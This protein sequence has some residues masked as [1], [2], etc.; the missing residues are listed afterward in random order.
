MR[1]GETAW[2]TTP[3]GSRA[4]ATDLA[5][6]TSH[7]IDEVE[8]QARAISGLGIRR[9]VSSPLTR[10][11]QSAHLVAVELGLT[12]EVEIDLREWCVDVSGRSHPMEVVDRAL[13]AMWTGVRPDEHD[14]PNFEDVV[15]LRTR[16]DA[17][18]RRQVGRGPVL[19]VS[20]SVAIWSVTGLRILTADTVPWSIP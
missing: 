16:V 17:A 6:L 12:L 8:R 10:A 2:P 11:M 13:Y 9:V 4:D 20:H 19:V 18:L 14:G 5:P 7:G 1:H 15:D 3:A